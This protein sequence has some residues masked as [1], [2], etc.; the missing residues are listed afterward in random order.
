MRIVACVKQVP[1]TAAHLEVRPGSLRPYLVGVPPAINPFDEFAVEEALRL[2]DLH[3]G[4]V[5]VVTLARE[6]VEE[7]VFNALAMGADRAVI[8]DATGAPEPD[9]RATGALLAEA[10]AECVPDLVVCG[11]R[12]VD[13]DAGAVGAVIAELLGMPQIAGVERTECDPDAKTLSARCVRPHGV[14][15]HATTLPA[16]VMCMRGEQLPRY[17][18]MDGIFEAGMKPQDVRPVTIVESP[19]AP[20]RIALVAPDEERAAERITADTGEAV[21]QL[22]ERIAARTPVLQ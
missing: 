5:I 8:L 17:A 10:I 16:V 1:D 20:R 21:E 12:A 22:L 14:E 18:T 6:V 4:E 2:R 15:Y 13:D 19:C 11:D 3:G 9:A 7:T